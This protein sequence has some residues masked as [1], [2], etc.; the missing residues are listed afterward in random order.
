MYAAYE[1]LPDELMDKI[2]GDYGMHHVSKTINPRIVISPD[3]PGTK[4]F[5]EGQIKERPKDL[6]PI[7]RTQM[8]YASLRFTIAIEG[9]GRC[10]SAG[11]SRQ[12]SLARHRHMHRTAVVGENCYYQSGR[13]TAA[14]TSHLR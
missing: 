6:Q 13:N 5:Y 7:V 4:D 8:L 14:P 12:G 10:R 11:A 9:M 1:S 3:L 2:T